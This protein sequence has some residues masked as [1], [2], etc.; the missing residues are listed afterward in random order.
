MGF[1]NREIKIMSQTPCGKSCGRLGGCWGP[2]LGAAAGGCCR[3][4]RALIL[5]NA[6]CI[7]HHCGT[8]DWWTTRCIPKAGF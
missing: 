3:C 1:R 4:L 8:Q 6:P 7:L 2:P 5:Q